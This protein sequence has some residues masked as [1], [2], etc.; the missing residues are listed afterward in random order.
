MR[1]KANPDE[2]HDE[3]YLMHP[4]LTDQESQESSRI[5]KYY[6]IRSNF[7]MFNDSVISGMK[8]LLIFR[9]FVWTQ[10]ESQDTR[11]GPKVMIFTL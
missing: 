9:G 4:F 3:C 6:R 7:V 2:S 11:D 8:A 10:L 1:F 5:D